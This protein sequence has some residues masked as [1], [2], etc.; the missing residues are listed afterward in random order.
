VKTWFQSLQYFKCNLYRY[1]PAAVADAAFRIITSPASALSGGAVQ[2]ECSSLT[3]SLKPPTFNPR[4]YQMRNWFQSIQI[5]LFQMQLAPL[6][7]GR[8][9]IDDDVLRAVGMHSCC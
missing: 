8:H 7:S 5:L 2:V 6:H 1:T 3:H 9:F 4:A